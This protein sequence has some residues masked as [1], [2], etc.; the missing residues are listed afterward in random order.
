MPKKTMLPKAAYPAKPAMMFKAPVMM[1]YMKIELIT[2]IQYPSMKR[3]RTMNPNPMMIPMISCFCSS[4][5]EGR[6]LTHCLI[7]YLYFDP[8]I[9]LGMKMRTRIMMMALIAS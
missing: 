1:A 3:G 8:T 9:P 5:M 6:S 2:R 4:S 7:S